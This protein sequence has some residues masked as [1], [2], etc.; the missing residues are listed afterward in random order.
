M[1]NEKINNKEKKSY[2]KNKFW[3]LNY[4]PITGFPPERLIYK[5]RTKPKEDD[6]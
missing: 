3:I 1:T 4:N 5:Y 6:N 2:L